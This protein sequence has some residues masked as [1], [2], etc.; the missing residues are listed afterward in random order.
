MPNFK[1]SDLP[2]KTKS[3]H[4]AQSRWRNKNWQESLHNNNT[5]IEDLLTLISQ[6]D[7]WKNRLP[8]NEATKKLLRETISDAYFS[9]H[10]SSL[11]LYKYAYMSL[12]SQ[13]ETAM[14]LIFFSNHPLE[15]ELWQSGNEKWVKKLL[16][17]SDV[18]EK[19]FPTSHLFQK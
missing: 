5:A 16:R 19:D 17:G 13:F 6:Y 7:F 2:E 15:F 12:R 1:I 10:L 4:N 18:W 9:I 11:G 14:R 8:R 3:M